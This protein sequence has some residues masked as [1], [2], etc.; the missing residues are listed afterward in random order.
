MKNVSLKDI[1]TKAGASISSVSLVLNGKDKKGRISATLAKK[2]K[3]IAKEEGYVPNKMAVGLRTG[4]S[5][6]I[7]LI[8][9]TI[10]GHFFASLAEVIETEVDK[11][12]YKVI[13][14]STG[15]DT[16][17]GK[18]MIRM[19]YQY[20]VDGYFIIPAPG[21]EK[22]LQSLQ[23]Q[24]KP[25]VLI[26]SYFPSI[27]S[28]HVLVDNYD[29]ISTA[30]THLLK[31]GYK[32]VAF[33]YNDVSMVQMKMRKQGYT[34]TL[35]KA[36]IKPSA[37]WMLKVPVSASREEQAAQIEKFLKKAKP[38]SVLFAANYLGIMGI[39]AIR[40]LKLRIR[41]DIGV[42]CFDDHELFNLFQ[43]GITVVQQPVKELAQKAVSILMAKMG[44]LPAKGKEQVEIKGKL[45]Q[46]Q[47]T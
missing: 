21:M 43:P 6:I 34:E 30:V 17:K 41:E 45:I 38:D 39:E 20:Q 26:D 14:C 27:P 19:L 12:G 29:G 11:Y 18:D 36:G 42:V 2:I 32:R 8:V 24:G 3:A 16:K 46:R 23:D 13:Y 25:T 1:A 5:N 35:Q 22:E 4:R 28:A 31:K 44:V 40:N 10:N 7:G 47:S 15:N 9:D 33:V 37:E